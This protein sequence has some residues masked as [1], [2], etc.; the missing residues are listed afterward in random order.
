M[1][2][3]SRREQAQRQEDPVLFVC[4]L[5]PQERVKLQIPSNLCDPRPFL[6]IEVTAVTPASFMVR[7]Q[8]RNAG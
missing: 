8:A 3:G 2:G 4:R 6:K 5:R 1:D 7:K